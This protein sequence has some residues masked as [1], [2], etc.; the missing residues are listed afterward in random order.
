MSEVLIRYVVV[1]FIQTLVIL[2]S[3]LGIVAYLTLLERKVL[4]WMQARIGPNRVGPRGLLQPIAD[5]FKLFAKEDLVPSRA[6]RFVF[7][8]APM[9]IFAPSF[10]VWAV[11]PFGESF[12]VAGVQVDSFIAD[13]NI[14]I[15]FV[16]GVSSIAIYGII[17]G[18]WSSN[19]KFSLMGGLRSAAQLVSYEVPLGFAV[20]SVLLMAGTLSLVGIVEAQREAGIWFFLP[21]IL[22][23]GIYF[24]CGVAETGRNPFDLPEAESE[25]VGGYH[26]EYSGMKFAFFYLAEYMNMLV[27][28]SL[29]VTLFFGGWLP[30][31]PNLLA[32]LWQSPLLSWIPPFAWYLVKVLAFIFLYIWFRATFPRYRFDQLMSVGWKWLIPLSLANVLLVGIGVLILKG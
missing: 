22:G 4:A 11:I 17:L 27:V 24:I 20:V 15:L 26:T 25:L 8:L 6:E 2:F 7:V 14:A 9:L 16:L 21:G 18:G 5:V 29:A 31:F 10:L 13:I 28:S 23:F 19:N 12:T 32:G 30:P 1:P 3:L